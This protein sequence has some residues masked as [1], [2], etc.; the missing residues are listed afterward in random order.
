MA[1]SQIIS[2]PDEDRSNDVYWQ[3][4]DGTEC[5]PFGLVQVNGYNVF[6]RFYTGQRSTSLGSLW[7]ANGPTPVASGSVGEGTFLD[8]G[9][10]CS[11]AVPG[12]NLYPGY[13]AEPVIDTWSAG[14]G[15]EFR[16]TTL[17]PDLFG[18]DY[19]SLPGAAG[20]QLIE[21]GR[22]H[23]ILFTSLG[24]AV[25]VLGAGG[26]VITP[27]YGTMGLMYTDA[28]RNLQYQRDLGGAI[29]TIPVSNP[30]KNISFS[31]NSFAH[32]VFHQ[33]HWEIIAAD[34]PDPPE[35][36]EGEGEGEGEA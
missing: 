17:R 3:N 26:L 30:F 33:Q 29:R 24:P 11:I 32:A 7:F 16:V 19:Q 34:C 4:V 31:L 15:S 18:T 10:M 14:P 2:E 9:P 36:S 22:R 12:G 5:P 23:G 1:T 8:A 35:E 21:G 13:S 20:L 27:S 6:E 28:N 25:H